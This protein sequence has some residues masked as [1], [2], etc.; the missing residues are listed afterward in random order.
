MK[1]SIEIERWNLRS[2]AWKLDGTFD[3]TLKVLRETFLSAAPFVTE[4]AELYLRPNLAPEGAYRFG[5]DDDF[6]FEWISGEARRL[7]SHEFYDFIHPLNE[8]Q[9]CDRC[10][11]VMTHGERNICN[12]CK[13]EAA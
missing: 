6:I 8:E 2:K 7:T 5:Q 4:A 3:T 10:G 1:A 9:D 13:S 12:G 11:R